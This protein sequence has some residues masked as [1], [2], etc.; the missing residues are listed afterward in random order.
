M[1]HQQPWRLWAFV[2]GFNIVALLG[3][4]WARANGIDPRLGG[5]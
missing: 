3:F 1:D 2:I 5:G 4:L